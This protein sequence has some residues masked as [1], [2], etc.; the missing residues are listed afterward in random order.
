MQVIL[1]QD[2]YVESFAI[3]GTLSDSIAVNNP[4]DL[5]DFEKNYGSYYLSDGDNLVKNCDK[6]LE[7]ENSYIL[8][9]LRSQREKMCFKVINRGELWYS[10]LT[11]KQ[12]KELCAW[13]DAW[14]NVTDTQIIPEKPLWLN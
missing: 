2:G 9:D 13:Y 10:K 14:L 7:I 4:E 6:Q 11:A 3:V 8:N 5:N 1:N 12:K